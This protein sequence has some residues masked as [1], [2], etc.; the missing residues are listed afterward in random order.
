MTAAATLDEAAEYEALLQFLYLAPVGLVQTSLDGEI[1]FI[2][3]LS[4]QLLM[5]LARDGALNNLFIALENVAPDLRHLAARFEAPQG[6]ICDAMPLQLSASIAGVVDPQLLSLTLVKMDADRLMAV[7]SDITLQVKRD[8]ELRANEAV[9]N[10]LLFGATDYVVASLDRSGC[11]LSCSSSLG[12]VTGFAAEAV[13]GQPYSVFS[14]AGATTP[15]GIV[16]RLREADLNGWSLYDGWRVRADGSQFWGSEIIAPLR[17]APDPLAESESAYCLVIRDITH[18]REAVETLRRASSSDHMTGLANRRAFFEAA[19]Q[20]LTRWHRAPRE[21]ALIMFDADHF[22]KVNDTWGHAAGDA[23][24]CDL[25]AVL[26]AT[27]RQADIVA[28]VGGEEF[29]ALL[30]SIGAAGALA[31]GNRLLRAV[32]ARTVTVD[33]RVIHY[34]VS[35]GVATMDATVSGLD[36]LLKRADAALYEAKRKGRNRVECWSAGRTGS[37]H[38]EPTGH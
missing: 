27:F 1:E 18:R 8:R 10:A 35:A 21:L 32:E 36:A 38:D 26:M 34:T 2:N 6:R 31:V 24:L 19:Q 7:L 16:D 20:E 9:L 5:P 12:A 14:A 23:V 11:I 30:P 29:V 25:A 22:K 4:A 33:D 28:R 15:E 37:F 17:D 13:L 3:P